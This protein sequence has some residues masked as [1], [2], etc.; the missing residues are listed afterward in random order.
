[1]TFECFYRLTYNI[2]TEQV[3]LIDEELINKT[4]ALAV[5]QKCL[6]YRTQLDTIKE[7]SNSK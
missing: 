5:D 1:M 2:L 3:T 6:E 7:E 4:H